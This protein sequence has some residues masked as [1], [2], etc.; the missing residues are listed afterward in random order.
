[1]RPSPKY[2]HA[3]SD[4]SNIISKNNGENNVVFFKN[5]FVKNLKLLVYS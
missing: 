1:M 5:S 4:R 3:C 2:G